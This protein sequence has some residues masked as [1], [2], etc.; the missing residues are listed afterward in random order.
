MNPKKFALNH[1]RL[2]LSIFT[3]VAMAGYLLSFGIYNNLTSDNKNLTTKIQAVTSEVASSEAQLEKIKNE[4]E[5]LKNQ[6]QYLIN[7]QLEADIKA[8]ETTYGMAVDA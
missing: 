3:L 5:E 2:A 4:L 1:A 6:D 8:I 7:K